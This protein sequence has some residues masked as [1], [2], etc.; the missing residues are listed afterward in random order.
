MQ[1]IGGR[2]SRWG[3]L[4]V[5]PSQPPPLTPIVTSELP[6]ESDSKGTSADLGE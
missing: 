5:P 6:I 4:L 1:P 2:A 3:S